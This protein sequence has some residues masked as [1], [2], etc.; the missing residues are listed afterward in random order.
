MTHVFKLVVKC[1]ILNLKENFQGRCFEHFFPKLLNMPP[2]MKKFVRAW[3]MFLL[4]KNKA[5]LPKCIILSKKSNKGQDKWN[6]AY[7]KVDLGPKKKTL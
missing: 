1:E 5:Y 2:L 6:N 4:K 7:T 3:D